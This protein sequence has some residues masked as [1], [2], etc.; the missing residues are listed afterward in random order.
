MSV[1]IRRLLEDIHLL[2]PDQLL[3]LRQELILLLAGIPHDEAQ[4]CRD[5]APLDLPMEADMDDSTGVLN[6]RTP[7]VIG[8]RNEV[9]WKEISLTPAAQQYL[10]SILA[11]SVRDNEKAG[12]NLTKEIKLQ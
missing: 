3:S 5:L 6:I 1:D 12:R 4:Y 8:L 11:Q 7:F 10:L 9:G 2:S